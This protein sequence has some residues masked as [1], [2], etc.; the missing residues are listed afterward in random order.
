[1]HPQRFLSLWYVWRKLCTY[2]VLRLAVS[3]NVLK[4]DPLEPRHLV[5]PF[6]A[7]KIIREP[8]IRLAQTVLLSCT[9]TST[10]SKRTKTRFHMT[11]VTYEFYR[12][13]PKQN[14][15]LWYVWC[16]PCMSLVLRLALSPNVPKE[17][18]LEPRHPAVPS[19][20]S[21]TIP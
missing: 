16:K 10:I 11:H 3:P 20:A 4:E 5:V 17:V 8:I 2:L 18:P 21:K 1:V 13:R 12:V 7:S 14:L 6:G 9:D 19:S 15:S